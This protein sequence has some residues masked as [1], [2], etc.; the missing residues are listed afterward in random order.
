MSSV[1]FRH[2]DSPEE[3]IITQ[4]ATACYFSTRKQPQFFILGGMMMNIHINFSGDLYL[5]WSHMSRP[6]G[7]KTKNLQNWLFLTRKGHQTSGSGH[8]YS[9]TWAEN[10]AYTYYW[11]FSMHHWRNGSL[12]GEL[13]GQLWLQN[14]KFHHI[15]ASSPW[16]WEWCWCHFMLKHLLC[17]TINRWHVGFAAGMHV[18]WAGAPVVK[19]KLIYSE[20]MGCRIIILVIIF[21]I[22]WHKKFVSVFGQHCLCTV[23]GEGGYGWCDR[24]DEWFFSHFIQFCLSLSGPSEGVM[25]N[26]RTFF[27]VASNTYV[28][29]DIHATVHC[30]WV[31]GNLLSLQTWGEI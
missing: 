9:V 6:L 22:F 10:C 30:S 21:L 23:E 17:D 20:S 8:L 31:P 7:N 1:C 14:P 13:K 11:V 25:C 15:S 3:T 24:P 28:L 4:S 26:N 16:F 19:D 5:H 29:I 12:W 27:L 2:G 18:G